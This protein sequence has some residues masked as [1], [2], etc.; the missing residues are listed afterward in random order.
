M[1]ISKGENEKKK[2]EEKRKR[3]K[4]NKRKNEGMRRVVTTVYEEL[5]NKFVDIKYYWIVSKRLGSSVQM[6]YA[7][8]Q[9]S[10]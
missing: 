10:L 5:L 6:L 4:K 1:T 7:F 8:G 3:I 2:E 9:N